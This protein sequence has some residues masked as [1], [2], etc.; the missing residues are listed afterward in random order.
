[1][2]KNILF[3][4]GNVIMDFSPDYI[5]S[6]YTKDIKLL[7]KLKNEIFL[8]D[9]WQKSD[10]GLVDEDE[11]YE[12]LIPKFDKEHHTL[13]RHLL[14]TW[15][16][17]KTQNLKMPD[18]IRELKEKGYKIYLCSNAAKSFY[19]YEN[20]ILAF[21]YLDGKV[22]SADINELKPDKKYFDYVLNKFNLNAD[23]CF[24]IDDSVANIKAAYQCGIDGYW[25]NGNIDIFYKFLKNMSIL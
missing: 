14:S 10:A 15:Y 23:E 8:D 13:I 21:S 7:N 12:Y 22:I 18:I 5:L 25:Y 24:F 17:H 4:M 20:E 1:M 16:I 19:I 11:I 9:I 6:H 3:D 2:Y